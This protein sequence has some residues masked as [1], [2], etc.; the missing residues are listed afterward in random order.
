MRSLLQADNVTKYFAKRSMWKTSQFRAV[1]NVSFE[2]G[3]GE[4]LA[5]VGESGSGKSTLARMVTDLIPASEGDVRVEGESIYRSRQLRKRLPTHVQMIFQ[6]PFAALNPHHKIGY[7]VGRPLQL[8]R[9]TEGASRERV[10]ELLRSVGLTPAEEFIEKYPYQL[11][12]GQK[13]R[14]MIAKVLGLNPK[15]IIADE[16]TSM[17]DVSIGIDIMN[18]MLD[19]KDRHGLAFMLITHNL[20]SAR[21]M[22]DKIMVM[23]A[24]KV[25]ESGP[26]EQIVGDPRHPYTKLLLASSPDPWAK[27]AEP[28]PFIEAPGVQP[29]V[30]GCGFRHRCPFAMDACA[31]GKEIEMRQA[32]E[33][34]QVRCILAEAGDI[35]KGAAQ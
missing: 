3:P 11:S 26:A 17:L 13:Q 34:H 32:G 18:L 25:V 6:D 12:G 20:G 22:A 5:V 23:F 10:L 24:G 14:V 7:I 15:V 27:D 21:Y 8:Q 19:L 29:P 31:R 16:P 35:P 33:S 9:K 30:E 28:I 4:V 1:H 2:L